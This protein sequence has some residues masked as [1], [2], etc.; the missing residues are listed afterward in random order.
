MAEHYFTKKPSSFLNL[1]KIKVVISGVQYEFFSGSGVFSKSKVDFGS[2]VL[3]ENM[4]IK[5]NDDVLDLGC[6]IGV[7]G[8]VA[9]EKTKGKVV[10]SDV[11][12]RAVKLSKMNM[13]GLDNVEVFQ[14]NMYENL[15]DMKFDVILLNP[16]QTAGKK[17]CLTLIAKAKEYLK[18]GGSLQVVARHNKGGE[19]LS[20]YMKEVYGNLE[21]LVKEGGYRVYLSYNT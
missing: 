18:T 11:N 6:G 14:G 16:P 12:K 20:L 10:L 2:R 3:A 4:S 5:E 8:R 13:K 15:K 21:T 7:I 9:R 17:V 19:T 1:T